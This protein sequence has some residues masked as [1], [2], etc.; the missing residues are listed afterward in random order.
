MRKKKIE[1]LTSTFTSKV[2]LMVQSGQS[3]RD[4]SIIL[5]YI[6]QLNSTS[7][8]YCSLS[9]QLT[10]ADNKHSSQNL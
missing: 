5:F 1:D 4:P 10:R 7:L 3:T 9:R 8:V 2:T 6:L